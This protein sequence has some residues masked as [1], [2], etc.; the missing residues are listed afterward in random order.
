MS[1]KNFSFS[2]PAD[3]E[4]QKI[5]LFES[6][7]DLL[8]Y[9]TIKKYEGCDWREEHLLSLAGVYQ[10]AKQIEQSKIPAALSRYLKENPEIKGVLVILNTILIGF[11]IYLIFIK[12]RKH[13]R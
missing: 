11:A 8:S 10:P 4:S 2:I 3:Y 12:N 6:A 7:I 1:D 9:A 5:H 13:I